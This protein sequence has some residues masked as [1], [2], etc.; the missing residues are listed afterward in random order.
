MGAGKDS[1]GALIAHTIFGL[2]RLKFLHLRRRGRSPRLYRISFNCL[3]GI[4][5]ASERGHVWLHV[6]KHEPRYLRSSS[7]IVA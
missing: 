7:E 1:T 2:R 6:M 4:G 3:A 5:I